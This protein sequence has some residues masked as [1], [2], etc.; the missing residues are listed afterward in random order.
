MSP[1][2]EGGALRSQDV[3]TPADPAGLGGTVVRLNPETGAAMAG[4]PNA[5]SPDPNVRRIVASGLRNPFRMTVRP[6]TSEV[7]LGDVGWTTWEEINRLDPVG[8][9]VNFGWPCWS[10]DVAPSHN[11]TAPATNTTYRAYYRRVR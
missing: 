11:I 8:P 1:T 10:D 9:N 6:G 7:W 5:G 2:A 4:N 3:R